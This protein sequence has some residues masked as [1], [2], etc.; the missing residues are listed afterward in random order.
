M[1][2][3]VLTFIVSFALIA[4][5]NLFAQQSFALPPEKETAIVDLSDKTLILDKVLQGKYLFEHD[6]DRMARGE[7]CMYIYAFADGKAGE[8]VASFH[9]IPVERKPVKTFVMSVA[10]SKTPDVYK[11]TEVQFAGSPKG[12]IVPEK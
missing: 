9:C 4:I 6:D 5:T 3:L 2:R 7:A 10:T 12:H 1:R 11:L 8:L